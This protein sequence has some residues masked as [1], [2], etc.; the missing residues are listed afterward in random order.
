[1][2]FE[3]YPE[4][5]TLLL[6]NPGAVRDYKPEWGWDRYMVGGKMFAALLTTADDCAPEYQNH[7]MLTVKVAP[8]EGNFLQRQYPDILPGYYMNKQHWI[9]VRLDGAVP[10]EGGHAP[11]QKRVCT[12]FCQADKENAERNFWGIGKAR[13]GKH[14]ARILFIQFYTRGIRHFRTRWDT[15]RRTNSRLHRANLP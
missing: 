3:R 14:P 7:P 2:T 9:S 6:A 13:A 10:Q 12:D 1:M 15:A 5:D 4:L 11:V 8:E